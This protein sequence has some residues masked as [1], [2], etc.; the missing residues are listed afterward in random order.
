MRFSSTCASCVSPTGRP[1]SSACRTRRPAPRRPRDEC[2]AHGGRGSARGGLRRRRRRLGGHHHHQRQRPGR[3]I[4]R[5]DSGHA[6]RGQHGHDGRRAAAP[7]VPVRRHALGRAARQQ[8]RD[9]HPGDLRAA[10]LHGGQR[11]AR[12]G[13]TD[14]GARRL[15]QRP[16]SPHLVRRGAREPAR[17]TRP[18]ARLRRRRDPGALQFER[19][20]DRMPGVEP[21]VLRPRQPARR[22][23]RSRLRPPPR[24]RARPR[25]PD[26]RRSGD[27]RGV[28]RGPRRLRAAHPRRFARPA[29]GHHDG[30]PSGRRPRSAPVRSPGTA[31][32]SRTP[33]RPPCRD[34][35]SRSPPRRESRETSTSA[36]PSS[37]R[38]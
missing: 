29:L 23:A 7:G 21:V 15:S 8:R 11:N 33:S 12:R 35:R 19:R 2:P 27:G 6:D 20:N 32:A 38:R 18:V 30:L 31:R 14:L 1:I 3:R 5:P 13:G 24:I 25:F 22:R 26:L 17:R 37:G 4:Q 16:D 9:P 28:Q 34:R 10:R 36:R